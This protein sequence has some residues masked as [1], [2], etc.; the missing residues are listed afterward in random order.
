[1]SDQATTGS[2]EDAQSRAAGYSLLAA[3][4]RYPDQTQLELL[5][6]STHWS[7]WPGML[8]QVDEGLRESLESVRTCIKPS[9]GPALRSAFSRLF[10]HAVRG[11]CPPYE[12]EYGKSEILQQA[13]ELADIAG[14]YNAFGLTLVEQGHERPDHISIE[15]EFMSALASKEAYA[16]SANNS[17]A[18]QCVSE[19]QASFLTDHLGGWLPAFSDRVERED[20]DGLYGAV[21]RFAARFIDAE[22][23]RR[24][25]PHGPR[26]LEF[27]PS[28]Q[29]AETSVT[30]GAE[31][32][33]PGAQATPPVQLGID[34]SL[35]S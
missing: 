20:E 15:C 4:F 9:D 18:L 11:N 16:V 27:R 21:A 12:L 26:Y 10:G 5:T 28:D 22:C 1:M 7:T 6:D 33:C 24:H 19:A 35:K 29:A 32:S 17:E 13:N 3:A 8:A 23:D 30:C 14:F 34:P 25:V 31:L 2:V